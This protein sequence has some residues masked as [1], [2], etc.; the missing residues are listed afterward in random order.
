MV[1]AVAN[2]D[3]KKKSDFARTWVLATTA[4]PPA[5]V[6]H[7]TSSDDDYEACSQTALPGGQT[8]SGTD[9]GGQTTTPGGPTARPIIAPPSST[10]PTSAGSRIAPVTPPV[11]PA[12]PASLHYSRRPQAAR[13]PPASPLL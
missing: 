12:A 5:P 2:A 3:V 1:D 6:G 7:A 4:P 9:V 11:P 10:S 8:A 13:E